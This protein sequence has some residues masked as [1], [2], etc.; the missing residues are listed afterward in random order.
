MKDNI[1][2]GYEVVKCEYG[3]DLIG[4]GYD[5]GVG[6]CEHYGPS[7]LIDSGNIFRPAEQ[8]IV[9]RELHGVI[10]KIKRKVMGAL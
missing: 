8:I 10:A 7:G 6:F 5:Q 9:L 2:V 4:S 3:M 1:K